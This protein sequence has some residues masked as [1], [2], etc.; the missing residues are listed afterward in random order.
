M[1][2]IPLKKVLDFH[3]ILWTFCASC[4]VIWTLPT[5]SWS[6]RTCW[7]WGRRVFSCPDTPSGWSLD[8]LFKCSVLCIDLDSRIMSRYSVT[9]SLP[10]SLAFLHCLLGF[11]WDALSPA[12][13]ALSFLD[14]MCFF[15][16]GFVLGG[17]CVWLAFASSLCRT[18][19]FFAGRLVLKPSIGK[20][21]VFLKWA[22]LISCCLL[23]PA[24]NQLSATKSLIHA[25]SWLYFSCW[26]GSTEY[27]AA[28]VLT[29]AWRTDPLTCFVG[30]QK[31]HV[32]FLH[33]F[34][35]HKSK[36]AMTSF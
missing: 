21:L 13:C 16:M 34:S 33:T 27:L 35:E 23:P 26:G 29:P 2:Y 30:V 28:E 7:L 15:T 11:W 3:S 25:T 4:P 12:S 1:S 17:L 9:A 18:V 14:G 20:C 6:K 31:C 36:C 8:E 10:T 32:N 24:W 22:N 19:I 5:V